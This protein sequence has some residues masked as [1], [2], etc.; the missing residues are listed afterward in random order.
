MVANPD[1]EGR[2][3][4][5]NGG[6][7]GRPGRQNLDGV[8][9]ITAAV[10]DIG[11][12]L[13]ID[14]NR[15]YATGISNG[16]MMSFALACNTGTFAAIGPDSATQ[17]DGCAAPHP[18]SVMHIHGTADRLIR[19]DGEPG[20]GVARIDGPAVPDLNAFWR[21]VDQCAPP[22]TTTDGAV[23]TSSADCADGR[24]VVL[25]TVA[26]G[27]H[28]WPAFATAALW[29]F[30]CRPSATER[31]RSQRRLGRYD[32][33]MADTEPEQQPQSHAKP[34]ADSGGGGA[35]WVAL[36]SLIIALTAIG[37]A[38][39][40]MVMAWP[41]KEKA[42]QP[43]AEAKQKVC[44]AFETVS[45]AVQLQTHADLGPDPVAQT[46]VASN[47]RLS[48]IG[49]GEYL[50]SRLDDQTPPD[51]AEAVRLFANNLEEIGVN[52]LAGI[53]NDDSQQAARL[54]AGEDGRNKVADLCK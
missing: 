15:V 35:R 53:T 6:C 38:A 52:A 14:A 47:A 46:A 9:F 49:G 13:G 43:T 45:K 37:V 26:G 7:C 36:L 25:K 20:V 19:Y 48:L 41:Q 34:P 8:G 3:W 44:A 5:T 23:T 31:L 21:G 22:E 40:A 1:G 2:A 54:T 28:E 24:S 16:G 17:L 27:G 11:S 10:N 33:R 12:N 32:S 50:M 42:V 4:N 39:W 29:Q 18:T 51:L 30:L